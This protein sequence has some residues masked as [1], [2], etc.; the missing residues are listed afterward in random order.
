MYSISH[1]PSLKSLSKSLATKYAFFVVS[2]TTTT[3]VFSS[4]SA[5]L[6]TLNNNSFIFNSLFCCKIFLRNFQRFFYF[7]LNFNTTNLRYFSVKVKC[8]VKNIH[9]FLSTSMKTLIHYEKQLFCILPMKSSY[10]I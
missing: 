4:Q 3:N 1:S 8:P 6:L 5:S 9:L 10:F 7:C 2:E